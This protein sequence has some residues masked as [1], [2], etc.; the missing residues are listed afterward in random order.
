MEAEEG[1]DI[2][3]KTKTILHNKTTMEIQE[4]V[5]E[6]PHRTEGEGA[7]GRLNGP[8]QLMDIEVGMIKEEAA[9][10][11]LT[12]MVVHLLEGEA[13]LHRWSDLPLQIRAV[14]CAGI[15]CEIHA[16]NSQREYKDKDSHPESH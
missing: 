6:C 14:S 8:L 9:K 1:T 13:D 10:G 12:Q 5:V 4:G 7:Q 3:R 11:G 15:R 16:N 2:R